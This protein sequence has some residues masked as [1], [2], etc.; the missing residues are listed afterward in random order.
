MFF[1]D[2]EPF[3]TQSEYELAL[4]DKEVIDKL[5]AEYDLSCATGVKTVYGLLKDIHFS[6]SLGNKFDDYIYEQYE[7]VKL[8]KITDSDV[9]S[10]NKSK[11]R[12]SDKRLKKADHTNK[13]PISEDMKKEILRE[14]KRRNTIR[15]AIVLSLVVLS[16]LSIGYFGLYYKAA[17]DKDAE[18]ENFTQLKDPQFAE[19]I[20][21]KPVLKKDYD[22]EIVIPE[23]LDEYKVLFNKNKSLIGWVK[24][25]DTIIDYPVMQASDNE[26]YLKHNFDHKK[27]ANGCIFLDTSCDVI[28]GNTNW[29]LYGHHMNNGKM[30]SSLIKYANEDFYK[31]HKIIEFDTIYEKGKYE[32]MYAF[33]SRVY[34]SDEIV[35]KYY[36]FIDAYSSEEFDSYMEEM[37]KISLIDTGVTASYGDKLLT[38]STCDYQEQNGRF[39]VVAKRIN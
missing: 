1:V 35:F 4:K 25:A 29:I 33:R 36:Q 39:V 19:I 3:R 37:D 15:T 14:I 18:S 38:L 10:D 13:E 17:Y 5:K 30:F 8:G 28:T 26:F 2:G 23:I 21:V 7:K 11:N 31:E 34:S 9:S 24:I 32:V 27:D 16:V 12:K 20:K 6:T 22:D